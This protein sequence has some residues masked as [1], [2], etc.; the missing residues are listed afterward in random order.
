MIITIQKGTYSG[1]GHKD[2][3]I[4]LNQN[5]W[6]DDGLEEINIFLGG[7]SPGI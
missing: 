2:L 7:H 4:E 1:T 5:I 3:K 6:I